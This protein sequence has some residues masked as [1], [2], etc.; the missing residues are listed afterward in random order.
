MKLRHWLHNVSFW[1]RL[2]PHQLTVL[3]GGKGRQK[4]GSI[5]LYRPVLRIR[6]DFNVEPDPA[7]YLNADP[8]PGNLTNAD[9]DPGQTL[10]P[11]KVGFWHLQKLYVGNTYVMNHTYKF[12][13][14][15][16]SC[17]DVKRKCW[18][19]S[20]GPLVN[21]LLWEAAAYLLPAWSGGGYGGTGQSQLLL[22]P[23]T[24]RVRY[25]SLLLAHKFKAYK[26]LSYSHN[27]G[28][29]ESVFRIHDILTNGFGSGSF[30]IH[31]SLLL[32][33]IFT[34]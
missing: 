10:L 22:T 20:W 25:H 21:S 5:S 4:F 9:P 23:L 29:L 11:Q 28:K 34:A 32:V 27:L 31:H 19:N 17:A 12:R 30:Y 15:Q 6:I 14:K 8:D 33:H 1:L 26:S 16:R 2:Y 18:T 24:R 3:K 7:A 13:V